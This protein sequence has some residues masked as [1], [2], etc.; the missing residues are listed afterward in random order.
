[1]IQ[2]TPGI[3]TESPVGAR[4][5]SRSR[6]FILLGLVAVLGIAGWVFWGRTELPIGISSED[7]ETAASKYRELYRRRPNRLDVLSLAGEM[8]VADGRMSTAAACFA[9]IPSDDRK[10]GPA[11]RLQA[12]QVLLKLNRA[13][14]AEASF[15]EFLSLAASRASIPA[16]HVAAARKR[17][18]YL[19]SVELRLEERQTVLADMHA[20]GQADLF[21]SKQFFFPHLLLWHSTTGRRRLPEWLETD[22]ANP[23]LRLAEGRYL[24]EEG[25]LDEARTWLEDVCRDSPG[26]LASQA[27]LLE[28]LFERNEWDAFAALARSLPDFV[29]G[30]PWL[31]TRLRGE[32][33]LYGANWEAAVGH[34]SRLLEDD[35]ANPWC[36]VGLARAYAGLERPTDRDKE[37]ERSLILSKIRVHLTNVQEGNPQAVLELA[38]QCDQIGFQAAADAFRQ[39]A[40]NMERQGAAN[41][42][43][44][45]N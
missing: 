12:G 16:E 19:L 38:S 35:P 2:S 37:Q 8:A 24:T 15:R 1:M 42:S 21:D 31:L 39:H 34:F 27:A 29:R 25:R 13:R 36:H 23:Q 4:R 45:Q 11:A 20:D 6:M 18:C 17:L 28:C 26:D 32:L 41:R 10:Y 33:D 30:E 43:N 5:S 40:A 7:Y 22:Q 9:A 14:D 44:R 3:T